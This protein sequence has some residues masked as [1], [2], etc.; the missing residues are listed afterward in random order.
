[1]LSFL[2]AG[3]VVVSMVLSV[4]ILGATGNTG[5]LVALQLLERGV[6]LKAIVRS[7]S[8]LPSGISGHV[9]AEVVQASLSE[10][11]KGEMVDHMRGCDAV[12][13]C[14]GHN[15]TFEGIYGEPRR[16]VRDAAKEV[17]HA[18]QELQPSA[19]VK[20]ITLN[21]VAV[22]NPDGSED[23]FRGFGEKAFLS[24]L[25]ALLPP[26]QDS[27]D[28]ASYLSREVGTTNDYFE[29]CAVRPESLLRA[30]KSPYVVR[31]SLVHSF[32]GSAKSTHAN[33]ADLMCDLVTDEDTWQKWKGKMPVI[34]DARDPHDSSR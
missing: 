31:E 9:K 26:L 30:E 21:T 2:L 5:G 1:M 13:S 34:F 16:L 20:F 18:T 24:F 14:L 32:F 11:S 29:W 4:L 28:T 19:P 23:N 8:R 3:F 6:G 7:A 22:D 33:I 10:L 15:G 12:I 17:F 27:R 25:N